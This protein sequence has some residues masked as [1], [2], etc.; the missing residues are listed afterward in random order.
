MLLGFS[1]PALEGFDI[2]GLAD[3]GVPGLPSLGVVGLTSLGVPGLAGLAVPGLAGLAVP[4][5]GRLTAP[6]LAGLI[7]KAG[8]SL[9]SPFMTGC[10]NRWNLGSTDGTS[11][12]TPLT[13]ALLYDVLLKPLLSVP[14]LSLSPSVPSLWSPPVEKKAPVSTMLRAFKARLEGSNPSSPAKPWPCCPEGGVLL[15]RT[16]DAKPLGMSCWVPIFRAAGL[17]VLRTMEG[18][19]DGEREG[20]GEVE[21]ME[22]EE[23]ACLVSCEE[24]GGEDEDCRRSACPLSAGDG[25]RGVGGSEEVREER[26]GMLEVELWEGV[27]VRQAGGEG[28]DA[29]EREDSSWWL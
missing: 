10:N 11:K 24:A 22:D 7:G 20:D 3:L 2:L 26:E 4:G 29:D 18:E 19:T 23:E 8:L 14:G 17:W 13:T 5:L 9:S 15:C 25:E 12:S 16:S 27:G 1:I 21:E 6:G 28:L